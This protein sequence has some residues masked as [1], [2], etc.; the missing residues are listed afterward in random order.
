MQ[1][2]KNSGCY[3]I[4]FSFSDP[5]DVTQLLLCITDTTTSGP[6]N[7]NNYRPD[8]TAALYAAAGGF[9]NSGSVFTVVN[10]PSRWQGKSIVSIALDLTNGSAWFAYENVWQFGVPVAGG[11]SNRALS[12]TGGTI[13]MPAVGAYS[14]ISSSVTVNSSAAQQVYSAPTGFAPWG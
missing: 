1:N 14:Y 10:S 5:L 9:Y 12:W 11:T 2:P 13:I 6:G 4:E 7:L 8:N 3:Y